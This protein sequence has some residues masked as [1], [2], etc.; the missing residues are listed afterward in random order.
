M[1]ALFPLVRKEDLKEIFSSHGK[2]ILHPFR[3]QSE[4]CF[5]LFVKY[6]NTET[7][8]TRE[9]RQVTQR[10]GAPAAAHIPAAG[11]THV[12]DVYNKSIPMHNRKVS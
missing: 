12:I 2:R 8:E 5:Y 11:G 4:H 1:V 3:I 10:D 7:K 9:K 6:R